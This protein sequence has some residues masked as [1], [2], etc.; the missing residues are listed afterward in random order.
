MVSVQPASLPG[1]FPF[2]LPDRSQ[3]PPGHPLPPDTSY[4]PPG[5]SAGG[6]GSQPSWWNDDSGAKTTT[7]SQEHHGAGGSSSR[8]PYGNN[9]VIILKQRVV[10]P[11]PDSVT[12]WIRIQGQENEEILVKKC[13]LKNFTT[14]KVPYKI[15]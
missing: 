12:L 7:S 4:P 14:K 11:D 8:P 3:P 10:D 2:G 15:V 6:I 5:S 13:T 9:L 1:P